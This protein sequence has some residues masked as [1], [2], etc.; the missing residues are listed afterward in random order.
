[1]GG[2]V[3]TQAFADNGTYTQVVEWHK[4]VLL[5]SLFLIQAIN[6]GLASTGATPSA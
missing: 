3:Y 4:Y 6:K 1:M 2:V 5:A